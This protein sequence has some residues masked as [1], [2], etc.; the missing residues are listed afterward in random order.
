MTAG[1]EIATQW[2]TN[3]SAELDRWIRQNYPNPRPLTADSRLAE[4]LRDAEVERCEVC[5]KPMVRGKFTVKP[6]G[7]VRH[8]GFGRCHTCRSRERYGVEPSARRKLS[9]SDREAVL[10]CLADGVTVPVVAAR[11]GVTDRTVQRIK[12]ANR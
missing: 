5:E 4:I 8:A 6:A 2:T 9:L 3:D 10:E 7:Y 1:F 11:F 12:A